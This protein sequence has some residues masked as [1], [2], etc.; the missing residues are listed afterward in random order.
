MPE[1]AGGSDLE[2][3]IR[4]INDY[5]NA[6]G[7]GETVKALATA[8]VIRE[9][10][11]E[12]SDAGDYVATPHFMDR[13]VYWVSSGRVSLSWDVANWLAIK[14]DKPTEEALTVIS[15]AL[16]GRDARDYE[17]LVDVLKPWIDQG[18]PNLAIG[19]K[20]DAIKY[21]AGYHGGMVRRE[22]VGLS[23][24]CW[25]AFVLLLGITWG[26]HS[27]NSVMGVL[28]GSSIPI[29][30]SALEILGNAEKAGNCAAMKLLVIN[31]EVPPITE[32]LL[33]GPAMGFTS[34]V[35]DALAE[36]KSDD[37]EKA[38][39]EVVEV[40]KRGY[41]GGNGSSLAEELYALGLVVLTAYAAKV[42]LEGYRGNFRLTAK[43]L[44]AAR[45]VIPIITQVGSLT[46]LIEL[47]N[48][49]RFFAVDNWAALLY[50][51]SEFTDH[52]E[53]LR[54]LAQYV[55]RLWKVS[56]ELSNWG[57]AFLLMATANTLRVRT[58]K[59]VV[60]SKIL[61]SL[62]RLS[63][64]VLKALIK[65]Y[66]YSRLVDAETTCGVNLMGKLNGRTMRIKELKKNVKAEDQ[67]LTE[68][69]KHM[70]PEGPRDS[71][72][73][74]IDWFL[75]RVYLA[76]GK[77]NINRNRLNEA[78]KYLEKFEEISKEVGDWRGLFTALSLINRA[79]LIASVKNVYELTRTGTEF[80]EVYKSA[81][82]RL[83][84]MLMGSA[85]FSRMMAEYVVY[86]G[87]NG[88]DEEVRNLMERE[89]SIMGEP[90]ISL[91][92]V[93][94]LNWL[95]MSIK[96]T[97][98]VELLSAVGDYINPTFMPAL[99]KALGINVVSCD[100]ACGK[101]SICK[102]ACQ[103]VEKSVSAGTLVQAV[104]PSHPYALFILTL[105]ALVNG[106]YNTAEVLAMIGERM[107]SSP[108]INR[109]FTNLYNAM[110]SGDKDKITLSLIKLFY[111]FI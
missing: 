109:L 68:F 76:L 28:A 89:R 99:K 30:K 49:S 10:F 56:N 45:W 3:I 104:A 96:T 42:G 48:Y 103:A 67:Q 59:C 92:T 23:S 20:D 40:I 85:M 61:S 47:L 79:R 105:N 70:G 12:A 54:V 36:G 22:F 110:R 16:M 97:S 65:A 44:E 66:T 91:A 43:S 106:D 77:I 38:L 55:D 6:W 26:G 31:N 78:L 27:I 73:H 107:H 63:N 69:L 39:D 108:V 32:A 11:K 8:L 21:I 41:E 33:V 46:K 18:I 13:L 52:E 60:F 37:V 71:L 95:G 7:D 57:M 83:K 100:D 84:S 62:G 58:N 82:E 86:L 90:S 35:L 9:L 111:Y 53:A 25:G 15:K 29:V 72:E 94:L 19:S 101:D 98:A 87:L 88:E 51:A 5:L 14:H 81:M 4:Q 102:L 74:L 50:T 75:A 80:G 1:K 64:E 93:L 34:P 17:H 24:E 2:V